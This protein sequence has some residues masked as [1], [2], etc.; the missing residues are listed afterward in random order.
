[1]FNGALSGETLAVWGFLA[2]IVILLGFAA[3]VLLQVATGKT[4]LSYLISEPIAPG[5]SNRAAES[6][7]VQVPIPH[8][9]L[10]HRRALPAPVH[11]GRHVH[12]HP[13]NGA[14]IARHQWKHLR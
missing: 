6:K 14:R 8:L 10:R 2:I 1:M 3:A 13:G 11:R 9:H 4:N 12:R 5:P 7:P